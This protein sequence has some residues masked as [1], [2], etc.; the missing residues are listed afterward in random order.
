[1]RMTDATGIFQH[2]TFT[3]P[4][5]DEGYCTDD[6]ARAFIL[7]NQ[8]DG[9]GDPL[10]E[11]LSTT[12]L[13][14]LAAAFNA[15]MLFGVAIYVLVEA[16]QR[17][18][19]PEPVEST[20]ML[21]VAVLGLVINLIAMR[22]LKAGSGE[23]L[24]LRGAYL[25][26]WADMLGSLAVLIGAGAIALTG[27]RWLDP[28]IAVLIGLWV[29]PRTW[30]LGRDALHLLLDGV[31]R[32]MALADIRTAIHAQPGVASVHDLHVW[33]L[34]SNQPLL[35]AH[36]EVVQ[37]ADPDTTCRTVAAAL[38]SGCGIGHTTLQMDAAR[39]GGHD[40]AD[41]PVAGHAHGDGHA[42]GHAH[43]PHP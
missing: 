5:F 15:V 12:Y 39:C 9:S 7:C 1:M 42:H 32:G 3:I 31:P 30:A 11:R 16:V 23:N 41:G 10:A 18:R 38:E 34:A 14:F 24:N 20:G 6:N 37:G 8:L 40:C 19:T 21:V 26:V 35:T 43:G 29:L 22:L 4:N 13:A 28:A 36:V 27:W 17:F 2:A 25:E 33:S